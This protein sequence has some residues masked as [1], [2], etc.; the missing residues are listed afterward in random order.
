MYMRSA[1]TLFIWNN[2][3][4]F[5]QFCQ[6][7]Q[8]LKRKRNLEKSMFLFGIHW[9][10]KLNTII[11]CKNWPQLNGLK[12]SVQQYCTCNLDSFH[13]TLLDMHMASEMEGNRLQYSLW[14]NNMRFNHI[15]IQKCHCLVIA[16]NINGLNTYF[17]CHHN[18][19]NAMVVYST[20]S[21][22]IFRNSFWTR[23]FFFL[24]I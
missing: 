9:S 21:N 4:H 5:I 15:C 12:L 19:W 11:F 8:E 20:F 22:I 14:W 2:V 3:C 6:S 7:S 13:C 16:C 18:S 23:F 24:E 17:K 1:F 10:L